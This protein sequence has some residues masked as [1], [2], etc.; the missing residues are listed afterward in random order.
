MREDVRLTPRERE[1]LTLVLRGLKNKRIA[2]DLGLAE[3]T[4]KEHVSA[5]LAKFDVPNRATLASEA[6]TRLEVTGEL[7]VDRGWIRHLFL[8][9]EPQI[10]ILRGPELRF[11]AVN[12]A[13]RRATGYRPVIGRTMREAFPELEGQGTFERAERIYATGRPDVEHAR[14]STFDRGNGIEPRLVDQVGQA[15]YAEDGTVNGVVSFTVDVTERVAERER[16]QVLREELA[17]VL[18][19]VPSGVIVTDDQGRIIKMNEAA[20]R[21]ARRP[22]NRDRSLNAQAGMFGLRDAS[23]RRLEADETPV[24]RALRGETTSSSDFSFDAGDPPQAV[25]I[26]VSAQPLRDPDGRIRGALSVFAEID[27]PATR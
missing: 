20:Q 7:G 16:S 17:V 23:D 19:L 10:A 13:F 5:L 25:R 18:D 15:L 22:F 3:Q 27:V 26:R 24:A 12:E 11:E 9:A 21:I 1:V 14:V 6:G 4:V 8:E 2:A